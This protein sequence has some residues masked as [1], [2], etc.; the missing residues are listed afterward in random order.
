MKRARTCENSHSTRIKAL[1]CGVVCG[2]GLGLATGTLADLLWWLIPVPSGP[3]TEWMGSQCLFWVGVSILYQHKTR[4][5]LSYVRA[6][7]PPDHTSPTLDFR[8]CFSLR[9]TAPGAALVQVSVLVPYSYG[10]AAGSQARRTRKQ[11]S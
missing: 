10:P 11:R 1:L 6:R 9:V 3:D 7:P 2:I 8:F 4:P 5:L